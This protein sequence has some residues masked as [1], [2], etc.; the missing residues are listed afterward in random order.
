VARRATQRDRR[1]AGV[2]T[3]QTAQF[4]EARGPGQARR[5]VW[6]GPARRAARRGV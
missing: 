1:G 4:G 5:G 6:R 3:A 2:T